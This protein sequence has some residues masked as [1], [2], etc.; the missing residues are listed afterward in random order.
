MVQHLSIQSKI[1]RINNLFKYF[2]F[3]GVCKQLPGLSLSSGEL[4]DDEFEF[5]R[6]YLIE[7]AYTSKEVYNV[8]LKKSNKIS[9][10]F[11]FQTTTPVE[12]EKFKILLS[13]NKFTMIV[14]GLNI[15]YGIDR[16]ATDPISS[17]VK[18]KKNMFYKKKN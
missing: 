4:S 7:S 2:L 18:V 13:R 12:F 8:S 9:T 5:L 14:D 3:S 15:L 17:M 10:I 16:F 11:V 1:I 6:N